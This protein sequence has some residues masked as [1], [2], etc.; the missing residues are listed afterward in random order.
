MLLLGVYNE[1]SPIRPHHTSFRDFLTD[2][3]RGQSWFVD[4]TAGHPVMALGCVRVLNESL[5]FNICRLDTS[6]APNSSIP[7]LDNRLT[8]F[9]TSGLSYAACNWKD[10]LPDARPPSD[11]QEELTVFLD[12]KL[13]FW[14]ELLSLLKSV[15]RAAPT[16]E[17]IVRLYDV[18]LVVL[19]HAFTFHLNS[20]LSRA[21]KV[22]HRK[23]CC[24]MQHP[25]SVDSPVS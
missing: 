16:L 5:T 23:S 22:P 3:A 20:Q 9:V 7:S 12:K 19:P 17:A 4:V 11:L 18:S 21:L 8:E 6:Y 10:H 13:L 14:F 1:T 25:S 2:K 24:S 15:N